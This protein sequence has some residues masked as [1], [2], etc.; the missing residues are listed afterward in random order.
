M[1]QKS[2][3]R[4]SHFLDKSNDKVASYPHQKCLQGQLVYKPTHS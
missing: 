1:Q 4:N 3:D 2:K